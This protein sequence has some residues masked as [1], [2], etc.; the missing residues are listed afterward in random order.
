MIG[1]QG[2]SGK[3][4]FTSV[5][6]A[7]DVKVDRRGIDKVKCNRAAARFDVGHG[8]RRSRYDVAAVEE[9]PNCVA[10]EAVV[11]DAGGKVGVGELDLLVW[12]GIQLCRAIDLRLITNGARDL[13]IQNWFL[14]GHPGRQC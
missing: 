3:S 13:Q 5:D 6:A 10:Q 11:I 2:L 7:G 1:R 14:V 9:A 8:R 12:V 4:A